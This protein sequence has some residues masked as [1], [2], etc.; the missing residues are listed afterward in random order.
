[1]KKFFHDYSYS[2][3]KMF[4]TQIAIAIFGT[5]LTFATTR[6]HTGSNTFDTFTLIV[7]IFSIIFYLFLLYTSMWEIGA[8]DAIQVEMG[9]KKF[10]PNTGLILSLLANIPNLILAVVYLISDILN[11]ENAKFLTRLAASLLEGMYF[12]TIVTVTVW[13][14]GAW[15]TLNEFSITFF[16]MIIPAILT[17]WLAYYMGYKNFRFIAPDPVKAKENPKMKK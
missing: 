7:S 15:V 2:A 6:A 3:V 9:K 11:A 4:V 5:A 13:W 12:G 16:A 10:M 17:C 14:E 8:K 1:M